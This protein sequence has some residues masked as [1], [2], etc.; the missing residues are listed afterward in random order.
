MCGKD[1][2]REFAL[3]VFE[4]INGVYRVGE[5][6][7]ESVCKRREIVG[8]EERGKHLGIVSGK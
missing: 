2:F 3:Y 1:S 5:K 7:R 8:F 6:E 4:K